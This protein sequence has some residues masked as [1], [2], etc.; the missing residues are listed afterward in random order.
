[1]LR[2]ALKP[3]W[4]A[5]LV[6]VLVA[7][8]IMAW[9]G[10][11]QLDRAHENGSKAQK[12]EQARKPTPLDQVMHARQSFP[13]R[14]VNLPIST[15]G[16]WD[17]A[18]QLLVVHRRD[19]TSADGDTAGPTGFWVLTPLRLADGSAVPVVRGWV[20][21]AD[22]PTAAAPDVPSGTVTVTGLLLPS[23]PPDDN[24]VP[25]HGNGLPA[26]QTDAVDV[27]QLIKT[28]PDPLL[29]G[30]VLLTGQSPASDGVPT[31][32][33]QLQAGNSA[34]ALQNLSYAI[35]W[36]LFAGFGLYLWLR[37][38]R[39]D[40]RGTLGRGRSAPVA[41]GSGS[42]PGGGGSGSGPGG[43]GSGSG[44]G[45]GGSDRV[46]AAGT[47]PARSPSGSVSDDGAPTPAVG[48]THP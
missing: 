39:E 15:T 24:H 42:G 12:Q 13:A 14:A 6:L 41:A 30:F 35:Q 31:H 36:F 5:L 33:V 20:A 38:V 23:E 43:G 1:V 22:D 16:T 26:G 48:G 3:R 9:L 4:L 29:T 27:T 17:A 34:M 10:Q 45:G 46:P 25:G 21:S 37:L 40:H 47:D 28:W 44:P 32:L 2:T 11:W 18:H 8:S 7:A 19:T